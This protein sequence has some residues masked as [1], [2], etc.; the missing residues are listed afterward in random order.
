M[1][2]LSGLIRELESLR[3]DH[4]DA[5]VFI[6]GWHGHGI[7]AIGE[8]KEITARKT[9]VER[10]GEAGRVYEKCADGEGFAAIHII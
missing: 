9:G 6:D 3:R 10:D 8:C 7:M 1:E 5:P 2:N 4:G